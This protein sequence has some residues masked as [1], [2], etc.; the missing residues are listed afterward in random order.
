MPGTLAL[1][2]QSGQ[3]T[4]SMLD[5]AGNNGVGS[6]RWCPWGPHTCVDLAEVLDFL[7]N[8]AQTHSIVVYLEGISNARR[9]MSALRSA[10]NAKPVVVL[11][12][13]RKP[14]GN[15]AA[16]TTVAPSWAATTYSM[17]PCAAPVRCGCD[18]SW[19]CSRRPRPWHHA[20]ARW[21]SAWPW[22]PMEAAPAC[23]QP[24]GSTK[25]HCSWAAVAGI[26]VATLKSQLPAQ[27]SLADLIDL[28]EDAGPQ[29]F[30]AAVAAAEKT[31]RST[32]CCPSTP[33]D[34]R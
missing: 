16:Q 33:Q 26:S 21:A 17:P 13:G 10:A 32:A 20:I 8:D 29:D 18:R 22:S 5:W 3:L 12:A 14:A 6:H 1:V 24:I 19:R 7:A 11:K 30:K 4:A 28:S 2:S 31:A 34:R 23:W 15:E 25:F 27:A 9:F